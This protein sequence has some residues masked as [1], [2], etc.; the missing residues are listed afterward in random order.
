MS[1]SPSPLPAAAASPYHHPHLT[2][3]A[4]PPD[5]RRSP[6]VELGESP[7]RSNYLL[8]HS[9]QPSSSSSLYHRLQHPPSESPPLPPPSVSPVGFQ[10]RLCS[11]QVGQ[12]NFFFSYFN[13]LLY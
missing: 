9:S 7:P 4:S 12:V 6:E 3:N 5:P 1:F 10:C 13:L 8:H 11:F 2:H